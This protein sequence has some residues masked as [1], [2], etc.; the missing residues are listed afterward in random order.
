MMAFF[1][2]QAVTVGK[3]QFLLSVVQLGIQESGEVGKIRR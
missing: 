3:T 2:Q 1:S